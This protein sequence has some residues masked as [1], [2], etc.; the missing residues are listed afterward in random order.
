[1]DPKLIAEPVEVRIATEAYKKNN[2]LIGQFI[3]EHMV[4]DETHTERL[5]LNK[6][7]NEFKVWIFNIISKGKKVPE[8][9]QF[10]AYMEKIFGVY[11]SCG[12]GWRFVRYIPNVEGQNDAE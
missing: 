5:G 7:Y 11:P 6:T 10:R 9:S 4:A 3:S 12:K 2:D 8:R 1:M